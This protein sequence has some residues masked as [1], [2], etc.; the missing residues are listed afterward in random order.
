MTLLKFGSSGKSVRDWQIFLVGQRLFNQTV[1][2]K[3]DSLTHE[4][5]I[6]F[7]TSQNLQPDGVVG[8][9]TV[10]AAMMLGYSVIVDDSDEITSDKFPGKP[11]FQPLITNDDRERVFGKFAYKSK[12]LVENPENIEVTDNWAK[13]NLI[14]ISIPQ[15]VL[16]K[17]SDTVYFHKKA[18]NQLKELFKEWEQE[19]LLHKVMTWEGAY[20]ARFV[21]GSRTTL[22]NHAFGSAFDINYAWNK[23]GSKPALV[24]QKGSVRELVEVA[25]KNGFYWGGHFS[26]KDGMHFEIAKLK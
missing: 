23:L 17:G 26:R 25:N 8:N 3:F 1:D 16:I 20:V 24:G 18:A 19:N 7:Q 21:R 5:T 12:P 6:V 22:S 4:S 11:D 15:L 2:G 9:K 10:G 13:V 14:K